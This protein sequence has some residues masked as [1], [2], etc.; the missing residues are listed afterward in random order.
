MGSSTRRDDTTETLIRDGTLA[1]PPLAVILRFDGSSAKP[2]KFVLAK[3]TCIIG[4][5]TASDVVISDPTVSRNHA[6]LSLAP[7]GIVVRDLGSRNGTFYLGQRLEKIILPPGSTFQVGRATVTVDAETASLG[8]V[9]STAGDSYGG[10][11][12]RSPAMRRL[13]AILERLEGSVV[14]VLV[15]GESGVGKELV[16]RAIHDHSAIAT[17][18]FVALNCGAFARELLASELFG[19]K[20][21]A[22]TGATDGRRGAIETAD[23]GTLFL[24][25]L[26]EM[27]LDVQ[28][29][30][31]RFLE[32]GETRAVGSDATRTVRV[33]VVAA[34]NRK[35]EEQVLAG[36]FREDLFYRLAVVRVRVA[37]LR[38]RPEDIDPIAER[39]AKAV[40]MA[41]LSPPFLARLRARQWPG[42]VRELRN[43]LQAYAVLGDLADDG[44]R[45]TASGALTG[46]VDYGR[47]YLEQKEELVE[48][49]TRAYLEGLLQQTG[50]NQAE[51][52]RLS[53]L[54]RTYV[55][56]LVTKYGI[57]K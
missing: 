20:K 51:A 30:L 2:D 3:G 49:F 46:L 29:M 44:A 5:G 8:D 17:G 57:G 13:F 18:P 32:S 19:H 22:F 48:R 28:P 43:V 14:P 55:G 47:P 26:G 38:E 36:Q 27:P 1:R 12:G 6:E 10:L 16:A 34:T 42:N 15:E 45:P 41:P 24:D 52:A 53:G 39:L 56:R 54:D 23:G 31:L 7:E 25:E 35:L 33:R 11:V 37:P 4:S 21:G 9:A 50:G 40:G